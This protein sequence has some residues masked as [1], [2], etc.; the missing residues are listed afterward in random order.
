MVV[1]DDVYTAN[2]QLIITK[3]TR[4]DDRIITKLRVY[5]IYNLTVYKG[6]PI[7][8]G[9]RK[10]SYMEKLRRTPEFKSF[11]NVYL[12][13]ISEIEKSF[14]SVAAGDSK[15]DMDTLYEKTDRVLKQGRSD[16]HILEMLQGIRNYDDMTFVHSLNVSLI[17]NIFS[18]W[19]KMSREE[20]RIITLAGLLHDIGK[21]FI[22]REIIKKDGILTKEEYDEVKMHTVRGYQAL[23][24][25]DVDV[26]IKHA[27]LLHHERCDGSGYPIGSVRDGIENFSK[28]VAIV[29][30]YDAMTSDRNY[31][32]AICPFKVVGSFERDGFFKFDPGYLMIFMERM[33]QCYIHYMVRLNDGRVGEI[34]M[35][36]RYALSRPVVRC[37]DDFID[38][39]RKQELSIEE[40]L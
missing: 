24:N 33:V 31:R 15:V 38:L 19:L 11:V 10:E 37:G 39:S 25:L 28:I 30:V 16:I 22:P 35:I 26:R 7:K 27:A 32:K 20:T 9:S 2:D 21:V 8:P 34:V 3:G 18:R 1:A 23:K 29:D 40:I 4:L 6:Y 14:Q 17:C 12:D 13:T 5:N 36:N